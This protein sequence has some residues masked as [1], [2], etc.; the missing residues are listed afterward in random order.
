MRADLFMD[1]NGEFAR[2]S[3]SGVLT[4]F[5]INFDA[6]RLNHCPQEEGED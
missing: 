5:K 6:R 4:Q 1:W 2:G 3:P